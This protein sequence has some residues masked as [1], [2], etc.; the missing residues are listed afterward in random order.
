MIRLETLS[1]T[2]SDVAIAMGGKAIFQKQTDKQ[3]VQYAIRI[4]LDKT[5]DTMLVKIPWNADTI[6]QIQKLKTATMDS[7]VFMCGV[8]FENLNIRKCEY[9]DSKSKKICIGYTATAD[10]IKEIIP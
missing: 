4:A 6:P 1:P 7:P 3:P 5:S 2:H 10:N 9:T 8:R